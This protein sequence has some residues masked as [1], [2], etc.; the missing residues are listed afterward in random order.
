MTNV[1]TVEDFFAALAT[2]DLTTVQA[3]MADDIA[4]LNTGMPTVRGKGVRRI[5]AALPKAAV[6]FDCVMHEISEDGESVHTERT[7]VLR[8][9]PLSSSFHVTGEFVV[10]DGRIHR[11]DDRF[12][13][14]Q[15][16]VGF[17]KKDDGND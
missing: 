6:D 4:W 2:N 17:F 1:E 12:K 9:G 11:W 14:G 3:L 13:I 16:L 5:L 7:D 15:V 10:R 8:W